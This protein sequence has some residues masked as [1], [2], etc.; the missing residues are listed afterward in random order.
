MEA[1]IKDLL[2]DHGVDGAHQPRPPA[3]GDENG[4][5]QVA[6]RRLAVG[7]GDA[8]DGEAARRKAQPRR[9]QV[10]QRLPAAGDDD[11]R[12]LFRHFGQVSLGHDGGGAA[13]QRLGDEGMPVARDTLV[14]HKEAAGRH[15]ARIA[16]DG[17][18]G[19]GRVAQDTGLRQGGDQ[20]GKCGGHGASIAESG[21]GV[22]AQALPFCSGPGR[23]FAP[24]AGSC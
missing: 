10:G 4:I 13:L 15:P 9:R 22:K 3:G 16:G 7:A 12:H 17:L 19:E 1:G 21:M 11:E 23:A 2:A 8:D 14:G 24:Q 20:L 6:G 18:D 5:E